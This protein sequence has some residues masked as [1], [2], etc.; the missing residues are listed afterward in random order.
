MLQMVRYTQG[1]SLCVAR[2]IVMRFVIVAAVIL[3]IGK[4]DYFNSITVYLYMLQWC[5]CPG[6]QTFFLLPL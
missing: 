1:R 6:F 5:V 3:F 2:I 4:N